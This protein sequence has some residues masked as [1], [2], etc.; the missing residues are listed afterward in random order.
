MNR[1]STSTG[2]IKLTYKI[3]KFL[4]C[5][6]S[7]FVSSQFSSFSFL[8]FL[9]LYRRPFLPIFS[10]KRRHYQANRKYKNNIKFQINSTRDFKK[11]LLCSGERLVNSKI[12][13][14]HNLQAIAGSC[15]T[16]FGFSG[17]FIIITTVYFV[18]IYSAY[19]YWFKRN[20]LRICFFF[21]LFLFIFL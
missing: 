3:D 15:L 12:T 20:I 11:F 2:G 14:E 7:M 5:V 21:S 4:P 6:N 8:F 13:A 9:W 17:F 19:T 10:D 1:I 16:Y 18:L